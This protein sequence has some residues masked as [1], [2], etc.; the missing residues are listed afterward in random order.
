MS[1]KKDIGNNGN[2]LQNTFPSRRPFLKRLVR[3]RLIPS[4]ITNNP[5]LQP[6]GE[7]Y[8]VVDGTRRFVCVDLSTNMEKMVRGRLYVRSRRKAD[9]AAEFM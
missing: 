2:G 8:E 5:P 4:P 6:R 1:I 7:A 9:I 3:A